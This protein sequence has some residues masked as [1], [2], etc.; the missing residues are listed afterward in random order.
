MLLLVCFTFGLLAI[1]S[2][3]LQVERSTS[4]F[5]E[6]ESISCFINLSLSSSP[7]KASFSRVL[8]LSFCVKTNY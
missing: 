4:S 7:P 1:I 6:P 8:Y 5:V 3:R 2:T